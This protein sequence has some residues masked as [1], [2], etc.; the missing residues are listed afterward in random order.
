M[1]GENVAKLV[2]ARRK[3]EHPRHVRRWAETRPPQLVEYNPADD[4]KK[5]AEF[6]T[7]PGGWRSRKFRKVQQGGGWVSTVVGAA[8]RHGARRLAAKVKSALTPQPAPEPIKPIHRLP[9]MIQRV[10]GQQ[11]VRIHPIERLHMRMERKGYEPGYTKW[12]TGKHGFI[13]NAARLVGLG[14]H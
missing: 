8:V 6:V 11:Y 1:S 12:S 10:N 5:V 2:Q 14:K 13:A 7:R 9:K 3:G 4:E